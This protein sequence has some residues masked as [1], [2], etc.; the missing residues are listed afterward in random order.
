MDYIIEQSINTVKKPKRLI[1]FKD[2][3]IS[4]KLMIMVLLISVFPI[5]VISGYVIQ[6]S[7][8]TIQKELQTKQQMFTTL[9]NDRIQAYL[10]AR[11]GDAKI[12]SSSK[13]ICENVEALNAFTLSNQEIAEVVEEFE[14]FFSIPIDQYGYTDIFVTN[15]YGEIAYSQN[16]DPLDLA[17]LVVVGDYKDIAMQGTQA[18]SDLLYNSFIQDNILVLSTPVYSSNR[19]GDPIGT[20]NIVLNQ[21]AIDQIVIKGIENLGANANA[22]ILSLE[23]KM[24]TNTI[25]GDAEAESDVLKQLGEWMQD[26]P[27]SYTQSHQY[28]NV[29]GE[30]VYGTISM[31]EL[32]NQL[33][34]L[35][36]ET[37]AE[38][39]L[40]PVSDTLKNILRL[41]AVLLVFAVVIAILIALSIRRPIQ[42]VTKCVHQL[43]EY[44]LDITIDEEAQRS[45]EIGQLEAS[46]ITIKNNLTKIIASVQVYS[47]DVRQTSDEV[48]QNISNSVEASKK[49]VNEVNII[50]DG[51]TRQKENAE[52][53]FKETIKLNTL[54]KNDS[55]QLADIVQKIK[56]TNTI[57]NRGM[58]VVNHNSYINEQAEKTSKQLQES[59]AHSHE[60]F[61]AIAKASVLISEIAKRTNLLS[62]NASIEAARAGEYGRGFAVVAD[63]IRQLA[64]QSNVYSRDIN[65]MIQILRDETH[66]VEIQIKELCL[67][68]QQQNS[69]VVKTKDTYSEIKTSINYTKQHVLKLYESRI[70][71]NEMIQEVEKGIQILVEISQKN[72]EGT[73]C[74]SSAVQE[75]M[76][77]LEDI[78]LSSDHLN[79]LSKAL[80]DIAEQF[81]LTSEQ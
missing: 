55:D 20:V 36:I 28:K 72:Q 79:Q 4:F 78:T 8:Q 34:G 29:L 19:E 67:I 14:H 71:I 15:K 1:R 5:I 35:V 59:I 69:S 16:Y 56:E 2:I 65:S 27:I 48:H 46:I 63:E 51:S 38:E 66:E 22:Y 23:S 74:M 54:I 57:M 44:D 9:T 7:T 53:S 43:A 3:R 32:G 21:K 42:K 30:E 49:I 81:I 70:S 68:N 39:A 76:T 26:K 13:I 73:L 31:I 18:W 6:S 37:N 58:E 60:S 33:S 77:M 64:D 41:S 61:Q 52:K 11:E 10:T 75:Q 17:P 62:L 12:L 80:K 45:D 25:R 50:D 47:K 24:L 40:T